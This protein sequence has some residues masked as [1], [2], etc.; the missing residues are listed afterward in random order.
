MCRRE[1][2]FSITIMSPLTFVLA[3]TVFAGFGMHS[4]RTVLTL[5]A[6]K[7]GAPPYAIGILAATSSAFPLVLS[8][9]AGKLTD[10]LG[11]RWPLTISFAG[12]ALSMFIPYFI[13][14]LPAIFT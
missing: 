2:A 13:Q 14:G 6:L 5:Y 11:A 12:A 1:S 3:L 9:Y 7:L 8:V 4:G 10:R